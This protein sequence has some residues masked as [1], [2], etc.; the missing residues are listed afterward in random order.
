M[1]L[2]RLIGFAGTACLFLF[3]RSYAE[4]GDE[5]WS[6]QTLGEIFGSPAVAQ[7]GSIF[8][9]SR[10]GSV[11]ALDPEGQLIWETS[12]GDWV[13]SSPTLNADESRI[14]MGAWNNFMYALSTAD[15]S[16]VWSF[17]TGSLIASSPALDRDGNLY[18]GSSDGFFYSLSS[19]GV[20]RWSYF[21]GAELD[22]SAA[23][24]EDGSVYVGGYD[25]VLY[26]FSSEGELIWEFA[27]R[28]SL[29]S[30]G[31]RIA[32][33]LAIG[34]GG[35]VYFGSA[36][37]YCYAINSD[38]Q[39]VWEFNTLEK[40]DS[41]VVVGNEGELIF[42]S[43][44]GY[45][46]AVDRFG[47]LL[48]ESF[49]G[50]VFFSTP[51]VDADGSIYLGSYTGNGISSLN[52]LDSS[53]ELLWEYSVFDYI[54]SPPVLS[55][56]GDLLFGCYDGALYAIEA[57]A[58]PSLSNWGRFGGGEAN[59]SLRLPYEPLV[60]S[61]RF[62][63]WVSDLQLDGVFADPCFDA[64]LDGH[65]LALEYLLG[66]ES[67]VADGD[68]LVAG[69]AVYEGKVRAYLDYEVVLGDDEVQYQIEFS[70]EG[71][72][73]MALDE[74]VGVVFVLLDADV[75]GSGWYEKRRIYLPSEIPEGVMLRVRMDC[76]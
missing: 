61:A 35:I 16:V 8:L 72:L 73:W 37:G 71:R 34:E 45:V 41:G 54:D 29:E 19:A 25:G 64:D 23:V 44:N 6:F 48:W 57:Q 26:S 12:I 13:D 4:V 40:V 2:A 53:G 55:S 5:K 66:G 69:T 65:S 46:Y 52:A 14:Y 36:D 56:R 21:V 15:G 51:M 74:L 39:L 27:A 9:G 58:E 50:D 10:D 11:Y 38:G 33:P 7:D 62:G 18:F 70:E 43:R 3:G 30:D 42:A 67:N 22:C 75:K 60:L 63:E 20:E 32:G 49:V 68:G 47:V 1:S 31:S 76:R 17:E 28:E 59:R 24:G